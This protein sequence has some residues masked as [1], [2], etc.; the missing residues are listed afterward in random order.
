[1]KLE[2][3]NIAFLGDSITEGVGVQDR[4]NNRY[5]NILARECKLGATYNYGV[6]G[7]RLAH[8]SVPSS[9]PRHDLC[10]CGRAYDMSPAAD[11]VVVYGGI[12]DYIHGDAPVGSYGDKT[13][14]TFHGGVWFLMH[15]LRDKYPGKPIVFMT[16]ARCVFSNGE[17]VYTAPSKNPNKKADAMPVLS[18]V[19]IIQKTAPEFGIHVLDLYHNLPIDPI[20]EE[21]RAKYTSDGLHF[22]DEG[23]KVLAST[24]KEFLESI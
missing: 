12:N 13:P 24:L 5:D 4:K 22:N 10:F 15:L 7:S 2:G 23:H 9:N 18:Y 19:E 16:P 1:M 20:S 14:A 8:Q 11:V 3:K 17:C 6:S 21:V